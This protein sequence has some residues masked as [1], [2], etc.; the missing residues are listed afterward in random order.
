M[1]AGRNLQQ[2]HKV[3]IWCIWYKYCCHTS[4][5]L[6]SSPLLHILNLIWTFIFFCMTF[7]D[8]SF[9]LWQKLFFLFQSCQ[10]FLSSFRAVANAFLCFPIYS[11]ISNSMPPVPW[12]TCI[13]APAA[14]SQLI[15]NCLKR[16]FSQFVFAQ[17]CSCFLPYGIFALLYSVC[18]S[19]LVQWYVPESERSLDVRSVSIVL[20]LVLNVSSCLNV[21]SN[22]VTSGF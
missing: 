2:S 5:S 11:P 8:Y 15:K 19:C 14:S 1:H 21:S 17:S 10:T 22:P 13:L 16:P 4:I 6:A 20:S 7:K 3:I 18:D 9:L 12:F